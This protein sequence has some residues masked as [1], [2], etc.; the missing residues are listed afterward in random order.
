M[1]HKLFIFTILV[2][3]SLSLA[4]CGAVATAPSAAEPRTV[5]VNGSGSVTLSPDMA[6]INIGVVA[7]AAEAQ[8]ATNESNA[9][10]AQIT[11]A[12]TEL[13]VAESDIQ[14]SNF[15]IYPMQDYTAD[16]ETSSVTY[17]VEN[18]VNVTVRELDSLG[19]I[20]DAVIGAGANTIYGIQFDLD[21]RESAYAQAIDLAMQNAKERAQLMAD[22]AGAQL[23]EL[24][25]ASTYLGSGGGIFMAYAQDAG[26]G[27]SA[28]SSVPVS[29]GDMEISVEVNVVYAME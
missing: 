14:T 20:L 8:D 22:A 24:Q 27:D 21:D 2:V 10:I 11:A 18:T 28:E 9:T 5:S 4:A 3:A 12:L 17:R 6:T 7:Q 26:M 19:V 29:P 23:G 16:G 1:K 13:G 15:S 25:S